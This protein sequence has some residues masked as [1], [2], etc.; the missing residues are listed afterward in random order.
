MVMA[1][2]VIFVIGAIVVDIGLWVSQRRSAQAAAD[3]A[4]LAAAT[5]LGPGQSFGAANAKGADFAQRN[6]YNDVRVEIPPSHDQVTVEVHDKGPGLFSGIFGILGP[7]I[8]GKAT[9]SYTESPPGPDVA[10]FAS[11][12]DSDCDEGPTLNIEAQHLDVYGSTHSNEIIH[13]DGPD[14]HFTGPV[15][16][17]CPSGFSNVH[18]SNTYQ[19]PPYMVSNQPSP[20]DVEWTAI[21]PYCD[22]SVAPGDLVISDPSLWLNKVVCATGNLTLNMNAGE[23]GRT[24]LAARGRVTIVGA[25]GNELQPA[26]AL[27]GSGFDQLLVYSDSSADPAIHLVPQGGTYRGYIH[28]PHSQVLI[29]GS[30]QGSDLFTI[31]GSVV[32][33]RIRITGTLFEFRGAGL[34]GPPGPPEIHLED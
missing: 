17:V 33:E 22:G 16:W 7:E 31:E 13:V 34:A 14:D 30:H 20:L 9:A 21:L 8:G 4:A 15:T 2:T 24:T 3:L 32:A 26:S 19:P 28:A 12:S 10:L 23:R 5:Q 6:G 18:Q 1:A 29:D 11:R 25:S 27:V